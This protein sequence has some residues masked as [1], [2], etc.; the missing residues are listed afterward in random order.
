[1]TCLDTP[2]VGSQNNNI[3]STEKL[4]S[5]GLDTPR[6]RACLYWLASG[7]SVGETMFA[8]QLVTDASGMHARSCD[9]ALD[10][11]GYGERLAMDTA[12]VSVVAPFGGLFLA[13]PHCVERR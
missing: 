9:T 12:R 8:T 5:W 6:Q 13:A 4:R 3:R 10:E 1:M 11:T 2:P 7:R